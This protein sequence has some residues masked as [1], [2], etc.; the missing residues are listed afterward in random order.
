MLLPHEQLAVRVA[1]QAL[2]RIAHDLRQNQ[3]LRE[4]CA[5]LADR[6]ASDPWKNVEMDGM[7]PC[8]GE[9]VYIGVNSAG[10]PA[11]F[12]SV[13]SHGT[14]FM[15]TAEEQ[16]CAMSSLHWWR[17]LDRPNG[18]AVPHGQTFSPAGTDGDG[19]SAK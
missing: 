12:N 5:K 3:G 15:A 1:T 8:D 7:P 11:C 18:V 14:C 2:Q 17:L 13:N 19:S 10:Y 6:L 4:E 16:N 9:T